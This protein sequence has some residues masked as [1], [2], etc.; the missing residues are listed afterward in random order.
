MASHGISTQST[1][2]IMSGLIRLIRVLSFIR[3]IVMASVGVMLL[4]AC[5]NSNTS[6]NGDAIE[7]IDKILR[8]RIE[9]SIENDG[10]VFLADSSATIVFEVEEM[11]GSVL[12]PAEAGITISCAL[13]GGPLQAC[14]SPVLF[15]AIQEGEHLLNLLVRADEAEETPGSFRFVIDKTAPLGSLAFVEGL[16]TLDPDVTVQ[17]S[18]HDTQGGVD[19]VSGISE[20]QVCND[21][22]FAGC[23][24]EP[25][26]STRPWQLANSSDGPKTVY[27]RLRDRA[28]N[29]SATLTSTIT[30]DGDEDGDEVPNSVDNC[31]LLPNAD[32]ANNDS[33]SQGDVCDN[34]DDNDGVNDGGDNCPF[35]ANGAGQG[36]QADNDHDALGDACDPDDD[37]D[38]VLDVSD[39]CPFIK[40]GPAEDDQAN[41][42]GDSLGDACDS[43]DDNDGVFD[44]SDNCPFDF[45]PG[46]EHH[47][48]DALGDACDP[49]D[50]NDGILDGLDNCPIHFNTN[51][52]D[53]ES[54]GLGDVCDPDDDNDGVDDDSDNCP[55]VQNP[56]Q[57]QH[58]NDALGDACDPDDDNDGDLDALDNCPLIA[59][60]NQANNDGDAQGDV[61]DPDDDNDGIDDT[62]DN[63]PLDSN[64]DQ[65][66]VDQDGLGDVCDLVFRDHYD[67]ALA[68]NTAL[69]LF[70]STVVWD[71]DTF[72]TYATHENPE[73]VGSNGDQVFL[74]SMDVAGTG[75]VPETILG[76]D[77][78]IE[79]D[80][81]CS[82][83]GRFGNGCFFDG[84]TNGTNDLIRVGHDS[85]YELA[86]GSISFWYNV[87]RR[88]GNQQAFISKDVSGN[89]LGG[90]LSIY[91]EDRKVKVRLQDQFS[92]LY[93]SSASSDTHSH[94]WQHVVFVFGP[95]GMQ[96]FVDAK[97][98][99]QNA[100]PRGVSGNQEN[101]VLGA[102]THQSGGGMTVWPL[103][104]SLDDV[105]IWT[106]RLQ[107][108]EIDELFFGAA[109]ADGMIQS[110]PIPTGG[111]ISSLRGDWT[112]SGSGL[113]VEISFDEGT[114]WCPMADGVYLN[115]AACPLTGVDQFIYRMFF[116]DSSAVDLIQF[117]WS[118]P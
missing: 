5:N 66:D 15:S 91:M 109:N 26:S 37:N 39:N 30:I 18:G 46:Q 11:D 63:C 103:E 74:M 54:D 62:V 58:D 93:L 117:N 52:A 20:M 92:S 85:A 45:N 94:Q 75:T 67:V 98:V 43:D 57:E 100:D 28:G 84:G 76:N 86:E 29:V 95:G 21:P 61:C 78:V 19:T 79:G 118:H 105:V 17:I 8:I 110:V 24:W 89:G 1:R 31:P 22:M 14:V 104:G 101:L 16:A 102:S 49:D 9:R 107:A 13:D 69:D 34:D 42:D 4:T 81:D 12:S 55:L 82:Q 97:L 113:S 73:P 41:N 25:F 70:S 33:D 7:I 2:P 38:G 114:T 108:S 111:E 48:N 44:G 112:F 10:A 90:H 64:P 53:H 116:T 65:G 99:D 115:N 68:E 96:L 3:P 40:N 106:R 83:S 88:S 87:E 47:D 27:G 32:Q 6:S 60:S 56:G 80:V 50:D 72:Y 23:V 35:V 77:G 71:F 36:D 59:N 51:Q